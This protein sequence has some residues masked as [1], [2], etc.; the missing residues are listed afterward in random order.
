M[1]E[2][3][4]V[5]ML[6]TFS[7][8]PKVP[9]LSFERFRRNKDGR[10]F[11]VAVQ[12]TPRCSQFVENV[13]PRWKLSS[14]GTQHSCIFGSNW[15]Q[16]MLD[17]RIFCISSTCIPSMEALRKFGRLDRA[18]LEHRRCFQE[19]EQQGAPVYDI[20]C[21]ALNDWVIPSLWIFETYQRTTVADA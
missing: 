10:L 1:A 2:S 15:G 16:L 17:C 12:L 4:K 8:N 7:L 13:F 3:G 6:G 9:Q 20:R 14:Y 21:R 18:K 11:F 19:R 5:V